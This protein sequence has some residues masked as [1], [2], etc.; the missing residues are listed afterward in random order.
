[1]ADDPIKNEKPRF[2]IAFL[3]AVKD[4]ILRRPIIK[5]S[6]EFNVK[7]VGGEMLVTLARNDKRD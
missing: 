7:T 2:H 4:A 6:S 3:Q 1:M 5:F